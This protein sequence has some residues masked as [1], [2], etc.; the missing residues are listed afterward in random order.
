MLVVKFFAP[1]DFNKFDAFEAPKKVI[2]EFISISSTYRGTNCLVEL[3]KTLG[4]QY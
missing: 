3:L 4:M 1:T 2:L